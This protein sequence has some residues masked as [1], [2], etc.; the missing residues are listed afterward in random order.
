MIYQVGSINM[1]PGKEQEAEQLML[2]LAA[3]VKQKFPGVNSQILRNFDGKGNQIHIIDTW[4]SV[5]A[6]EVADTQTQAD[7]NWQTLLQEGA[8]WFDLSSFERH[9][10]QIVAE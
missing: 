9:F 5:G 8:A 10:Y 3:F 2:K 4:D 7:P 1:M 6:W